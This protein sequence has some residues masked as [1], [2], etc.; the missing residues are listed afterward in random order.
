MTA[1]AMAIL[2]WNCIPIF[3]DINP[4][5][6]NICEASIENNISEKTKAIMAVDIF[7]LPA[8]ILEI[9]RIAKKI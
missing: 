9:K 5:T 2:H 8:N 6:F 1:S 4:R 3:A 7:G